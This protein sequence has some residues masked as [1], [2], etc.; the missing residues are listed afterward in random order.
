M[1]CLNCQTVN[2]EEA[3]FCMNCGSPLA[4]AAQAK[5]EPM[6]AHALDKFI[7]RELLAKFEAARA[8]EAMVGE[9]R[10]I[11]MLFCDVKGSTAAAEKVDPETWTDVMNGIFEYMIRPVYKYEGTVPRL[12]GDA[13]LAFFGAPIAHEDD[14]QRAVLA[15]LEI[16]AGI[17]PYQDAMRL[18]HGLEFGLRVGIN[19]G[20]VVVGEIGSDL[21]ME[22]TAIGDAIN[23]AARM[24]QTAAAGTVQVSEDTYKLVAPLFEFEPL[25][26]VEVKG[27]SAPVKTFRPLRPKDVPGRSRGLEGLSSPLVGREAALAFLDDRLQHLQQRQGAFVT[28]TGEVGIGKSS[29]VAGAG[30][31]PHASGLTWLRGDSLSY[32]RSTSY[33][34]WRQIIRQSV[35]AGEGE[36]PAEVRDK[37]RYAC[38]CC[39]LPGGDIPFLE[40]LLAIETEES[41]KIVAGF[42]GEALVQRMIQATRGFLCGLAA[43]KPLALILDDLHWTDEASLNLLLH[44]ADLPKENPILFICMLRPDRTSPGW[45]CLGQIKNNAGGL[46]HSLPLEPL[47][48]EQAGVLLTNLLGAGGLPENLRASILERAEGNPFFVEELIRS[49]IETGQLIRENSHWRAG[50]PKGAIALPDNLRGV[51]GARIDRLPQATKHV[52]QVA[53]V[54]GRAFDPA[55]LQRLTGGN[56]G[57][58]AHLLTLREASLV[59]PLEAEYAFR[60]VLIQESAYDSILLKYRKSLHRQIGEILEEVH[61]ARLEEF[62]PLLAYHYHSAGDPRSLKYDLLAGEKAY[63]LY[64]NAEAAAHFGRALEVARGDPSLSAEMLALLSK[65][66]SAL[67]LDGRYEQALQTYEEM[68]AFGSEHGDPRIEFDALVAKAALYST[69]TSLHD[70]SLS[71]RTLIEALRLSNEIGDRAAQARLNWNLMLNYLFSSRL[72]QALEHGERALDLARGL[73][74]REQLAFVLNDL[75]RLYTNLGRN[76]EALASV[77]EARGLWRSLD[78]ETMLADSFGAEAEALINLGENDKALDLLRQG[79]ELSEKTGNLWGRSYDRMLTGFIRFEGGRIGEAIQLWE[80]AVSDGDAAGLVASSIAMRA[81]LGWFY[82]TYGDIDQGLELAE[83]ARA[84][85]EAKQPDFRALPLAIQVR[86]HLLKGDL[87]RAEKAAGPAELEPISIPYARYLIIVSLANIELALARGGFPSALALVDD[88]LARVLH[89]TS[90]YVPTVLARKADALI[91]LGRPAEARRTLV[92]ACSRAEASGYNHH[93]WSLYLSLARLD[94]SLG[95]PGAAAVLRLKAAP[96]VEQIALDLERVGLREAFLAKPEI[97][98][99]MSKSPRS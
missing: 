86:L 98:S 89:L 90:M 22:Y 48:A 67:E 26:E 69:Y 3:R 18:Q 74:D 6:G 71:E 62:A 79:L 83:H 70:P 15:G 56:G 25:G 38:D 65:L 59:E 58:E 99:L 82:G 64:A 80:Q 47:P 4:R 31:L 84:L 50:N 63:R 2:P 60:H 46:Y 37:L 14:P 24:E 96:V 16:Q 33:F 32:A 57:L 29:L 73:E 88:L 43:E 30:K 85:A 17:K 45:G 1:K 41:L 93:L 34:P 81:E 72:D 55:V 36:A 20:L 28:I 66:G 21:R 39:A 23:L 94:G 42:Q 12:M 27:K 19:T 7:P 61:A 9:R 92:E 68:Q 97:R 87:A 40:A 44:L 77:R 5:T 10:V 78:N 8:N 75:C 49:L 53:A 51:L 54:I 52:L 13:I 76:D 11:T 91:G 95:D 35:G